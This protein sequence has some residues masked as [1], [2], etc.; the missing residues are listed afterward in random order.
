MLGISSRGRHE[1]DFSRNWGILSELIY[2][3]RNGNGNREEPKSGPTSEKKGGV[4]A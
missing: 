3:R 4:V 2:G 1:R